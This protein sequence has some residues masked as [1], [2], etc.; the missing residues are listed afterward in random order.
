MATGQ[1]TPIR[2]ATLAAERVAEEEREQHEV[3]TEDRGQQPH[4]GAPVERLREHA[5]EERAERGPEERCRVEDAYHLSALGGVVDVR[6]GGCTDGY[7]GARSV[8][9]FR[10]RKENRGRAGEK[11][12]CLRRDGRRV[13]TQLLGRRACR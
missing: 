3:D 12:R 13:P 11:A 1:S 2:E 6:E 5:A 10:K 4:G 7:E 8:L 9:I